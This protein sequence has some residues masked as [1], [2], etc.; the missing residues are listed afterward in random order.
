MT[1]FC[2][3]CGKTFGEDDVNV[4]TDVAHCRGCGTDSSYAT[5]KKSGKLLKALHEAPPRNFKVELTD[6]GVGRGDLHLIY[7]RKDFRKGV[8]LALV[9]FLAVL[10][11]GGFVSFYHQG[12]R[13]GMALAIVSF[14]L[15]AFL[16]C[17]AVS[18]QRTLE[19][20]MKGGK[21]RVWSYWFW[22]GRGLAFNYDAKTNFTPRLTTDGC[23]R[24]LLT[25]IVIENARSKP[26]RVRTC[27]VGEDIE[28][29]YAAL[30]YAL[31]KGE[32]FFEPVPDRPETPE[33]AATRR[34][35]EH[36][37]ECVRK[38]NLWK[39]L[40]AFAV[41]IGCAVVRIWLKHR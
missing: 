23:G 4:R 38:W 14:F 34:V 25:R 9:A 12:D 29:L 28:F 33:E 2:P 5:L 40:L 35:E 8:Y 31:P 36:A 21:G 10:G 39:L 18:G 11:F 17:L 27:V 1:L 19:I 3:R 6:N 15:I 20:E 22:R 24:S 37:T 30:N 7:C 32:S 26:L 16:T 41:G 13:D